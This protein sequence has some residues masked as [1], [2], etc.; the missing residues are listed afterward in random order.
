MGSKMLHE[1]DEIIKAE[2]EADAAH[3]FITNLPNDLVGK[4]ED[5]RSEEWSKKVEIRTEEET[6][7]A[8][9]LACIM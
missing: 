6:S 4:Y 3:E 7:L 9:A 5:I 8:T 2:D 1:R